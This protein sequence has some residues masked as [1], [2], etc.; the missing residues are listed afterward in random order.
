MPAAEDQ[1]VLFDVAGRPRRK[2]YA[3]M[4]EEIVPLYAPGEPRPWDPI[5]EADLQ[6]GWEHPYVDHRRAVEIRQE[7]GRG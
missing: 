4:L 2:T 1:G 7:I 3:E 5:D 6:L